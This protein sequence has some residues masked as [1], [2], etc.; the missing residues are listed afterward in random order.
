MA[1]VWVVSRA[2]LA[3]DWVAVLAWVWVVLRAARFVD[4]KE[5]ESLALEL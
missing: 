2:V 1:W 4:L 5:E 3:W